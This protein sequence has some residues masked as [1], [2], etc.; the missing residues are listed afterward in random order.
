MPHRGA[1]PGLR[2]D[3]LLSRGWPVRRVRRV[4]QAVGMLGPAACMLL[5]VSPLTD[6]S[7]SAASA[8]V[9]VGLG[10]NALTLAGVS[11]SHL[12]IAPRN[13]GV[14]FAAGNTAA[15]AAGLLAVPVT[16][17]VLAGTGSWAVVFGIAS[18]H[19]VLGATLF[20]LW[21]GGEVLPQDG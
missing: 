12:D 19:Y 17:W 4:L 18:L 3:K 16:G 20:C 8:W 10:F 15:T 13:A 5:A 1:W 11:V 2:A 6:G 21:V 14:V 7:P 9:T